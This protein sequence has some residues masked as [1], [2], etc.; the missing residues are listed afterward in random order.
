MTFRLAFESQEKLVSLPGE[1][2]ASLISAHN[3]VVILVVP[4]RPVPQPRVRLGKSGFVYDPATHYKSLTRCAIWRDK[5]VIVGEEFLLTG[6]L[7]CEFN[8]YL[9]CPNSWPASRKIQAYNGDILPK[10]RPDTSNYIKLYEDCLNDIV[11]K[12]DSQ[13]IRV[14]GTKLYSHSERIEIIIRPL[15]AVDKDLI[16]TYGV[17]HVSQTKVQS[18]S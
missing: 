13:L 2:L 14:T 12:D 8:F 6:A 10:S 1:K 7:T 18:I 5:S 17:T 4:G 9:N 3:P 11:W 16:K 15:D